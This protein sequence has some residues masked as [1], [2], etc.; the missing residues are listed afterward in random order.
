[1]F[2]C[3]SFTRW[4]GTLQMHPVDGQPNLFQCF[5]S[6]P[7]GYHQF[8]YIADGEW[9]YDEEQEF[10]TD[11]MGNVN[12]QVYIPAAAAPCG[13]PGGSG[14]PAPPA[15]GASETAAELRARSDSLDLHRRASLDQQRRA[16]AAGS[17]GRPEA[18]GGGGGGRRRRLDGGRGRG[19]GGAGAADASRGG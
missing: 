3:G 5:V 13:M 15:P 9:R 18:A 11:P 4:V 12:N 10:V 2:L 8:K 7:P 17:E 1:M 19:A 14:P 6:L 16:S